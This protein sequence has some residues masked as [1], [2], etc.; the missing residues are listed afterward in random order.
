MRLVESGAQR[1][2]G[3]PFPHGSRRRVAKKKSHIVTMFYV[4][5]TC[6]ITCQNK[7]FTVFI[8]ILVPRKNVWLGPANVRGR[9]RH[10]WNQH[11]MGN[12]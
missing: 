7:N 6:I 10:P 5:G 4:Q 8:H 11:K 3:G 9:E 1:F 2:Q 12:Q